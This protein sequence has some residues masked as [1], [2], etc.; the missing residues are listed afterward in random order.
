[1]N[2]NHGPLGPNHDWERGKYDEIV[3]QIA[4]LKIQFNVM[5]LT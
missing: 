2:C 1:M 5:R 4:H 3:F